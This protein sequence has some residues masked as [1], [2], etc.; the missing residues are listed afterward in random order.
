VRSAR[1]A[2][3]SPES[4]AEFAP[5]IGAARSGEEWALTVLYRRFQPTLLGYLRGQ[6]GP[7]EAEDLAS[8]VWIDVARALPRFEGSEA[9]FKSLV[10]TVAWR[11]LTDHRRRA[12]H[13]RTDPVPEERLADRA[14]RD[15]P[16]HSAVSAIAGQDAIARLRSLLSPE[17]AQVIMLRVLADLPVEEV[18]AIMG[19]RAGAIRSLQHRAILRLAEELSEDA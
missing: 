11:R 7:S 13:R 12:G 1:R 18:A 2:A 10:F 6:A 16:E 3:G 8:E 14:G 9:G 5:L 19:K 4:D 15:D 17:Q